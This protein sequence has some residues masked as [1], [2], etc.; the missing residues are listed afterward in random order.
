M[1]EPTTYRCP[2]CREEVAPQARECSA[3]GLIFS[4]FRPA[5]TTARQAQR[6]P[7]WSA[8]HRL[9]FLGVIGVL[10]LLGALAVESVSRTKEQAEAR[11]V[12][13]R[14][15]QEQSERQRLLNPQVRLGQVTSDATAG[16]YLS[17][18][19]NYLTIEGTVTNAGPGAVSFVEIRCALI[20]R[21]TRQENGAE[22]T[23]AVGAEGLPPGSSRTFEVMLRRPEESWQYLESCRI[24]GWR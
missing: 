12:N 2:K 8:T 18:S 3:C 1:A 23:Y 7:H 6:S 17:R 4:R 24:V 13:A 20:H 14:K 11:E 10:V 9:V 16:T 5:A 21:S 19:T 15:R 22:L